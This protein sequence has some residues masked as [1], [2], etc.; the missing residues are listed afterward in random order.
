MKKS[1]GT[2]QSDDCMGIQFR[3]RELGSS[4]VVLL[5]FTDIG[6]VLTNKRTNG[7]ILV[8]YLGLRLYYNNGCIFLELLFDCNTNKLQINGYPHLFLVALS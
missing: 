4:T 7:V 2:S 5:K 6:L 1:S 8:A 3:C